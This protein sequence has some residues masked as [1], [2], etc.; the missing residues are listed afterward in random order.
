MPLTL[1]ID[2]LDLPP[3]VL[4]FAAEQGVAAYLPAVV[5]MTRQLFP[6]SPL[7]VQVEDDPEIANDRHIV[8]IV[9]D[10]GLE[11][12]EAFETLWQ[13]QRELFARCPAPLVCIF[14]LGMEGAR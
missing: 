13:W 3:E 2:S 6:H 1:P 8:L 10:I 4:T 11:V 9:T 5:Q 14:R 12:S 7:T